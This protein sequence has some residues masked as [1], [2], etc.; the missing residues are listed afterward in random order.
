MN[1]WVGIGRLTRDVEV[2][3]TQGSNPAAIARYTLAV[4]RKFKKEGEQ[5]ADFIPCVAFGKS[6]EFAE[7]WFKKGMKIAVVGRIQTGS[8]TKT[9]GTKVFT[10]DV[11][12]EEQEFCESKGNSENNQSQSSSD[13][14]MNIPENIDADLP[15]N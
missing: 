9:D 14:F 5:D 15:F 13:G 11:V 6:A 10:T 8:Y 2:R 12:V 4:D 1:K 3:Y 7:K